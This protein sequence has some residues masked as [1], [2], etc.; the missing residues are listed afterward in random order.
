MPTF[1]KHRVK[2]RQRNTLIFNALSTKL[3]QFKPKL[4]TNNQALTTKHPLSI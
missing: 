1:E 2:V 4:S 3:S